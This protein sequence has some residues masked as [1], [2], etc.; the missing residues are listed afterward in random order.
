MLGLRNRI[1]CIQYISV[2]CEEDFLIA[3][4]VFFGM[5]HYTQGLTP[6]PFSVIDTFRNI[7]TDAVNPPV[8]FRGREVHRVT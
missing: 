5:M 8:L 2:K 6:V 3:F 7:S 4:W 1:R